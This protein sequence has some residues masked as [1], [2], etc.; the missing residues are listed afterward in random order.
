MTPKQQYDQRQ[1]EKRMTREK[2]EQRE[3]RLEA[4]A[5]RVV[6]VAEGLLSGKMCIDVRPLRGGWEVSIKDKRET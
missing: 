2:Q 3:K 6:T 4:L 1:Q 5:D